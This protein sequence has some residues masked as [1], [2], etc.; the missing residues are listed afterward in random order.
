MSEMEKYVDRLVRKYSAVPMETFVL[1]HRTLGTA[2]SVLDHVEMV[3]FAALTFT[4][5]GVFADHRD[6]D[7]LIRPFERQLELAKVKPQDFVYKL[8]DFYQKMSVKIKKNYDFLR[9]YEILAF[10]MDRA[11]ATPLHQQSEQNVHIYCAYM[12]LL[13]QFTDYLHPDWKNVNELIV[14][15]KVDGTTLITQDEPIPNLDVAAIEMKKA[16]RAGKNI[17]DIKNKYGISGDIVELV[18][19]LREYDN[20]VIAMVPWINEYTYDLLPERLMEVRI[21]EKVDFGCSFEINKERF[22]R[23]RR[24][25]P[26][27]GAKIRV[28]GNDKIE[29]LYMKELFHADAIYLLCRVRMPFGDLLIRF[30]SKTGDFFSPLIGSDSGLAIKMHRYIEKVVLWAYGKQVLDDIAVE[31]GDC[32]EGEVVERQ[33]IGGKLHAV[34]GKHEGE[35][36]DRTINGYVRKLPTGHHACEEAKERAELLGYELDSDETYVQSFIRSTWVVRKKECYVP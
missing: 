1:M 19:K 24:T 26:T 36:E 35:L 13:M 6:Y 32:F 14:G 30:N 29:E 18:N 5:Y 22:N 9:L 8:H 11:F 21:K 15:I 7:D 2:V 25:L 33:S 27:N 4:A 31:W 3:D 20:N 10:A 12:D 28:K 34:Y 23:R 16:A 17:K